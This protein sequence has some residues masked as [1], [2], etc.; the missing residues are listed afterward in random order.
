MGILAL[1]GM[2]KTT[3][4][5]DREEELIPSRSAG[6]NRRRIRMKRRWDCAGRWGIRLPRRCRRARRSTSGWRWM[7]RRTT[8]RWSRMKRW[9]CFRARWVR[10]RFF[11][12][13]MMCSGAQGTLSAWETKIRDNAKPRR[14][15]SPSRRLSPD[16]SVRTTARYLA[17]RRRAEEESIPAVH[18]RC[19]GDGFGRQALERMRKLRYCR[20]FI[21]ADLSFG[22]DV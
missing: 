2:A 16:A 5:A 7:W 12:W 6:I 9:R 10:S 22:S 14:L 8:S 4:P 17:H 19:D 11:I 3:W 20:S 13:G 21:T 1:K 18:S 15:R